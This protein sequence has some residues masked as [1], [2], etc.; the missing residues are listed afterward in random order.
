MSRKEKTRVRETAHFPAFEGQAPQPTRP[1]ENGHGART[2]FQQLVK[3]LSD[4]Y[5][6]SGS[7]D[8]VRELVRDEIKSYADN[9][10]TD[11]LGN[12][13]ALRKGSNNGRKKIMVAAPLDEIGVMV[14]FLDA[15]GFARIGMLGAVKPL[16]LLG[17]RVRFENGV[18]GVIGRETRGAS[19]TE[20]DTQALFLDMGATSQENAPVRVG[21][22]ACFVSEFHATGDVLVGK[23]LGGRA[24]CAVLIHTLRQLKKSAH[25]VYFVFT[26]Q[27]Q[28]G[29][30]GA[31]AAAFALQPD[32]A[33]TIEPTDAH[34][35]PGGE[36][37]AVALGQGPAILV[38]DEYTIASAAARQWL[39]QTARR[40]PVPHQFQVHAQGAGDSTPIQATGAGIV[41]GVIALPTRYLHTSSEMVN[42]RDV[43]NASELLLHTLAEKNPNSVPLSY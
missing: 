43:L 12:L 10:R 23:A 6:P 25:D 14:T 38:Q 30:R 42:E 13:I 17:A 34:D 2:A 19:R 15:R 24:S 31:G 7:E 26:A 32:Y 29:A 36:H 3:R 27:H 20:I 8:L 35:I 39:T 18:T 37:S 11:A 1:D 28:V 33:F 22:A 16:T 5:G 9:I 41:T 40:I 21:D 4:A